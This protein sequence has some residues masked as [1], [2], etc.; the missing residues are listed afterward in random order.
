MSERI[1]SL[2]GNKAMSFLL[3]T[4]FE[5]E[6]QVLPVSN[7]FAALTKLKEDKSI[8]LLIIDVDF[9]PQESWELVQHVKSSR[10]LKVPVVVL[11]SEN[12]D[13]VQ[14]KCITYNID[15]IFYKPFNPIDMISAVKSIMNEPI[16]THV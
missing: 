4:I 1:L 11:S 8:K 12:S 2:N 3:Q 13:E 5:K 15:E 14:E 10:L 6:Y 7:V 9:Q 16:L